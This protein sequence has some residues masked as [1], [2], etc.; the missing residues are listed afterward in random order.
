[1]V[2]VTEDDW[3]LIYKS[4]EESPQLFNK[5]SDPGETK[6][7]AKKHED[8]VAALQAEVDAYLEQDEAPW[9]EENL[10]VELDDME[11]NQLRALGYGIQ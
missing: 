3:R 9:P 7:I 11:L 4:S 2:S 10:S 8:V 6:N 1:M 5:K